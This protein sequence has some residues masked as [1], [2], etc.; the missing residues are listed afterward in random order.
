MS[1]NVWVV[2]FNKGG[3]DKLYTFVHVPLVFLFVFKGGWK[4][5]KVISW[6]EKYLI[7]GT[8]RYY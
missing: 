4:Y 5:A 3:I 6:M 1:Y 7:A 2:F 8:G